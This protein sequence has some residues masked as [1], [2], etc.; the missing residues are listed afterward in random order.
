MDP[1]SSPAAHG[2]SRSRLGPWAERRTT[3]IEGL[4]H[5]LDEDVRA[6]VTDLTRQRRRYAKGDSLYLA[7][8]PLTVNVSLGVTL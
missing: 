6:R 2:P 7:G 8:A 3:G 5:G 4:L 1:A